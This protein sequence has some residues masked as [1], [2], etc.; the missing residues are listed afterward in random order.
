MSA[1]SPKQA[2]VEVIVRPLRENDLPE[3]DRVCRLA[4]GT[5]LE[6]PDPMTVFGDAEYVRT[7]WLADSD[8]AFGA[9]V[10]GELVGSIFATSWGSFGFFGP[11]SVRPDLWDKGIAKRL[12]ESTME[13]F[14]K[15]G[16][17]H[18]ALLTFANSGKHIALYQKFGFWPRFLTP[19]MSKAVEQK[20]QF[21]ERSKFSE[22]QEKKREQ[23]LDACS[24][25][26]GKIYEGLDVRR[27]IQAVAAQKLGET[28]LLW[29]RKELVGLAVC[30]CGVGSEAGS[31]NC[32]V[33]FGAVRP[34][35]NV[36]L[37]F[38]LLLDACEM[39]ATERGMS[40]LVA[41]M[42]VARHQAYRVMIERGFHMDFQGVVMQKP[43]EPGYNRPEVFVIDDL[44]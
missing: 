38:G 2:D 44:R 7:R 8:A 3:A 43:N 42:N 13:L 41:G 18:I 10:N 15:W 20:P 26:T 32:Y 24:D 22:V 14:D 37:N 11:L 19:I 35:E 1:Q 21:V 30:H 17:K 28:L 29:V 16:T 25:L 9:E 34:S 6:L 31:R 40:R 12:L 4:Y 27:E 36:R 23:C 39:L 33:K 5:F